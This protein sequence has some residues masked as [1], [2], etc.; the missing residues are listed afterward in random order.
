M[1]IVTDLE[2]QMTVG[3]FT[4][5]Q[6]AVSFITKIEEMSHNNITGFELIEVNDPEEW[7]YENM[8]DILM[9]NY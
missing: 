1:F 7:L 5:A 4:V 8:E 6:D 9:S 2:N 3:P